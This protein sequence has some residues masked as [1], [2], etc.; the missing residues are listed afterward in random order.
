MLTVSLDPAS[1]P[2]AA[3]FYQFNL[4]KRVVTGVVWCDPE[5]GCRSICYQPPHD[6][7]RAGALTLPGMRAETPENPAA[8]P[9]SLARPEGAIWHYMS[10]PGAR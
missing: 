8:P 10:G 2:P 9:T 6:P 7:G 4:V 3:K 5:P 1:A